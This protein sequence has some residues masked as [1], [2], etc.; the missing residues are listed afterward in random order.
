[1]VINLIGPNYNCRKYEDFEEANINVPRKIAK[2]SKAKGI[3]RLIH[4]SALG[5]NPNSESW[6]LKTKFYGE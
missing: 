4:F 3:K 1:M 6:D 2:V 5:V